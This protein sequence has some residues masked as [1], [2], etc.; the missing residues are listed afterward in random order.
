MRQ[1]H[2]QHCNETSFYCGCTTEL[3]QNNQSLTTDDRAC[4][5]I[6]WHCD[7][8]WDCPDASDEQ[9]CVCDDDEIDASV[10][11]RSSNCSGFLST[12]LH[13]CV[14]S[15]LVKNEILCQ[16]KLLRTKSFTG[17]SEDNNFTGQ[18]N[19]FFLQQKFTLTLLGGGAQLHNGFKITQYLGVG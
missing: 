4:I 12:D 5:P 17:V 19:C 11:A 6:A 16:P 10:C 7:G 18:E 9:N 14:P 2:L 1:C 13:Q 8:W 3:E 15:S